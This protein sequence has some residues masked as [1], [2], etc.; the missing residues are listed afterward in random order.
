[1]FGRKRKNAI[2]L[3]A[4]ERLPIKM[5]QK[6][7]A[8][9][10]ISAVLSV[11]GLL[12][13]AGCSGQT[14]LPNADF[15]L[16]YL[17]NE[18]VALRQKAATLASEGTN[19]QIEEVLRRLADPD[20]AGDNSTAIPEGIEVL[21]YDMKDGILALHF[22]AP[23]KDIPSASE[24]MLRAALVKTL[25]Q[26]DDVNAVQFYVEDKPLTDAAGNEL[27]A[28][29][30]ETFLTSFGEE[31]DDIESD[32]FTLYYVSQKGDKLV[33]V[34]TRIYYNSNT[35][36][37]NLVLEHLA[38]DP[39][40]KGAQAAI[41]DGVRVLDVSVSDGICYVDL[42]ANFLSQTTGMSTQAAIYAIVDSL[43]QLPDIDKVQILIN[44][45]E[46]AV[47]DSNSFSGLYEPDYSLVLK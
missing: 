10:K 31:T 17:D 2:I 23:Y 14:I 25:M 35:A 42:D 47:V 16:Y 19:G 39:E 32:R 6:K 20:E 30:D 28:Q 9:R 33:R 36:L 26:I 7:K 15:Y 21:S 27:G 22:S 1:M 18:G 46:N 8:L 3:P 40:I 13:L 24:V 12:L 44:N 4:P 5:G 29:N 41:A 34:E 38:Q 11:V 37:E 45:E 43:A